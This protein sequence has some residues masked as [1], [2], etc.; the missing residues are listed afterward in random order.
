MAVLI[1]NKKAG[2]DYH[3]L[4]TFQAGLSL[5]GKMVKLIRAKKVLLDGKFVIFQKNQLQIIGFGNNEI[6]ENV[7]LLLKKK[8]IA[9]IRKEL[10]TKGLTCI[11]LNIKAVGRWLKAEVGIAKG[12]KN[13]DKKEAIKRRDIDREVKRELKTSF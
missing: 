12:K 1:N 10:Q 8:E 4:E 6:Q 11:P 13:F 9:Q 3:I 5:S 2:F 7:V